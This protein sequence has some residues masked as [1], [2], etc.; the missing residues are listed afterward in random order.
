MNTL[1]ISLIVLAVVVVSGL[2]I[3]HW[4]QERKFHKQWMTSFGRPAQSLVAAQDPVD[5]EAWSEPVLIETPET[6]LPIIETP[7]DSL[8]AEPCCPHEESLSITVTPQE[9]A[10][11]S[12]S[13]LTE[14]DDE[15]EDLAQA[16]PLAPLDPLLEYGIAMYTLDPITSTAF[17][18]LIESPRDGN[19][20]IR[21][22]GY[23]V[24]QDK[25]VDISPWRNQSFT[26]VMVILQLADRQ[27]AMSEIFIKTLINSLE[28]LAARF[29][30]IVRA[31]ELGPA[32]QRAAQL[33]RFCIDVDVLIG[34]NIVGNDG[35]IFNGTAVNELAHKAGMTLDATGVFYRRN[36][37]GDILY[38]LCNQEEIPFSFGH[39]DALRTH[40]VT[41]L[42][43]VPRV[44]NGVAVFTEMAQLGMHMAQTLGGRLVD[45]NI[46]P[47]SPAGIDKIKMQ[48]VNIYQTM[49]TFEVPAGGQRALRLFN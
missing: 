15:S 27:G 18:A 24:E 20:S 16:L 48:L 33:D 25:W 4:R 7:F 3:Y 29:R 1:Q 34:L 11:S 30:G 8:P 17:T 47:L 23:T 38:T 28:Q 35:Q 41:L 26:D 39:M 32:L 21:W 44:D 45:D 14:P 12:F 49:E 31:E 9:Q 19:P 46:R 13:L 10:P 22:L 43:E 2:R 36:E 42:F 40:G 37:H 5:E 6:T